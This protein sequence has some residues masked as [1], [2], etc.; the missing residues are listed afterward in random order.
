[1]NKK[2]KNEIIDLIDENDNDEKVLTNRAVVENEKLRYI[3]KCS[4]NVRKEKKITS[5][6]I[7][8]TVHE[9]NCQ[10]SKFL[11]NNII[12]FFYLC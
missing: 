10:N 8:K 5:S 1:M 2:N 11:K 6:K 9:K 4:K 3:K 12:V 7:K